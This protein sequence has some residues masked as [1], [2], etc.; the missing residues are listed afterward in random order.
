[1]TKGNLFGIS[2]PLG[3]FSYQQ[4]GGNKTP[5]IALFENEIFTVMFSSFLLM[6]LLQV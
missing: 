5:F 3:K 4:V 1:M 2:R 6:P